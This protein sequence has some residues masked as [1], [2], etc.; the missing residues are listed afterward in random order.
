MPRGRQTRQQAA[1]GTDTPALHQAD[2]S[3]PPVSRKKASVAGNAKDIQGMRNE[4]STISCLLKEIRD[5]KIG[6]VGEESRR[7]GTMRQGSHLD[8]QPEKGDIDISDDDSVVQLVPSAFQKR[9]QKQKGRHV[10]VAD[11]SSPSVAFNNPASRRRHAT[12]GAFSYP[13]SAEDLEGNDGVRAQVVKLLTANMAPV[14]SVSK[15]KRYMAHTHIVR[16]KKKT[17]ASLGELREAEYNWG[18]LQCIFHPKNSVEERKHMVN[19]LEDI[20]EDAMMYE[21]EDVREWSEDVCSKLAS[22]EGKL[23]WA[24]DYQIDRIRLCT[25]QVRKRGDRVVSESGEEYRMAEDIKV[26]KRA[27]PCR[28]F[29]TVGCSSDTDHIVNGYR[30][31]HVCS[32]CIFQKCEFYSH[33]EHSCKSKKFKQERK[34]WY[35]AREQMVG[36]QGQG[37]GLGFGG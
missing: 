30:H 5:E 29:N 31:L 22:E 15:G 26:A 16:G 28:L 2:S 35:S 8:S 32:F 3:P 19:H 1:A 14:P 34:N 7:Q 27:P 20:N 10:S 18:F 17:K 37:H 21:W 4:L 23:T 36:K 24:H 33:P 25:S 11:S 9:G 13:E 6:H 12:E